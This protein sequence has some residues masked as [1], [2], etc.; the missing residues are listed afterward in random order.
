MRK[1][2]ERS[3]Q[4]LADNYV[5][6]VTLTENGDPVATVRDGD[7]FI[8]WN[9]RSD[10]AR[11][12]TYAM[13][14]PDFTGFERVLP[15]IRYVCMSVYDNNLDLP[16]VFPQAQVTDNLGITL[17]RNGLR[18]LR[19]AETE[20]Y[21]HV[22]FFFN[23]QIEEPNPGEERI[24]VPSQKVPSYADMPE[25]S[26]SAITDALIPEIEGEKYDF[27]LVNYANGDLVGHSADLRAGIKAAAVIDR[28][29]GRVVDTGLRHGYTI[30]V[31]G[32]HG[33]V[34]AMLYPDGSVNPSHGLNPVPFILISVKSD[35]RS[36][37]LRKNEGLSGVSPTIL[38][39]MGVEKP[40]VMSS[41]SL[42]S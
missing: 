39:L 27:I 21:A 30:L 26:A 10:R 29:L 23:S 3:H 6:P 1:A 13:T 33:N 40:K 14:L 35:L 17:S 24:L 19:I 31:T 34:E 5:D 9:F 42:I 11:Q 41:P 18:Q 20:K 28:C 37:K 36:V 25:M 22:T 38:E 32:D 15:D 7:A 8:M 4:L 16:V 12:I 2:L